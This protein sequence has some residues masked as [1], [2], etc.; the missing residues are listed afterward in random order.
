MDVHAAMSPRGFSANPLWHELRLGWA[1]VAGDISS[2][3]VPALLFS[4]VAWKVDGAVWE[5]LPALLAKNLLYFGLYIYTFCVTNQLTGIQED[6]KNKPHRPLVRGLVTPEA[7]RLRMYVSIGLFLLVGAGLGVFVYALLWLLVIVVHNLATL[8]RHWVV[9][10]ACMSLGIVVQLGA[11]WQL[12]TPL[13]GEAWRWILFPAAVILPLVS[14]Q[15]LRDMEGDALAGRRTFPQRYGERFTRRFLGLFFG[16]LPVALHFALMRPLGARPLVWGC[17]AVLSLLSLL[18][19]ARV[20][21]LRSPAQDHQT[22]LLL[23]YW[24]CALLA[25]ALVVL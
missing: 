12:V 23:T 2:A 11:A 1:F 4:L 24:Y 9:K 7:A 17:D 15:D 18:I 16:V 6:Q 8:A 5:H 19:A 22:Y 13:T 21:G 10:N 25:S 20:L 3:V 14:L